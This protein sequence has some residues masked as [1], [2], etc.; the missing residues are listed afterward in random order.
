MPMFCSR[1]VGRKQFMRFE[2]ANYAAEALGC[3]YEELNTATFKHH[4]RQIIQQVTFGPSRWGLED[5]EASSGLK[6]TGMECVEGMASGLYQELF[7]AVVSL[8]NRDGSNMAEIWNGPG[9]ASEVPLRGCTAA[10]VFHPY[11]QRTK[12]RLGNPLS[13]F[14]A[15]LIQSLGKGL[16]SSSVKAER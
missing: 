15:E 11:E 6:M 5:E 3:E 16:P 4:L 8:I 14:S 10:S 1:A 2:W 12:P 9:C 13:S 7:V